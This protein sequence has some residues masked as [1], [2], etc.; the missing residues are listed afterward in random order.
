MASDCDTE[1]F[2]DCTGGVAAVDAL[3]D[4]VR[5]WVEQLSLN[6]RLVR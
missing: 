4:D 1:G 2:S 3:A 6:T 5:V